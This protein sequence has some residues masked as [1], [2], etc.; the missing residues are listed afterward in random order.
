MASRISLA[1]AATVISLGVATPHSTHARTFGGYEC[2]VDCTGHAA[3]YRWAEEHDI[4]DAADC[5]DGRSQSFYEGCVVY[6]EDP[7]RGADLDD[8]GELIEGLISV[9]SQR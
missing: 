9:V 2:T 5:P 6:T 8:D 7:G 4:T 1:V 3:G